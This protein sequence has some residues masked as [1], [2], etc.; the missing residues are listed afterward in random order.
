MPD[1]RSHRG[2]APEDE[3]L[4]DAK[5]W[6]VLRAAIDELCW[7]LDRGYAPHSAAELVGNRH[8]LTARQ[9]MAVSR[10]A[11]TDEA[12]ERRRQHEVESSRLGAQELWID[13]L[14]VLTGVEAA[15][16]GG[17]LLLGCDGC[18]RDLASIH[19]RHH[20]V[21]E[22]LPAL[23]WIGV[24]T[25]AW[26][27]AGCRWWLDRPVA[28]TGRL[29]G[30]MLEMAAANG[31]AWEVE[32]VYNPDKMLI[33]SPAIV[34]SSDSAILDRCGRWVN[35]ARHTIERHVPT[36]RIIDLRRTIGL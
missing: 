33:E 27:V 29:K 34:A 14:N 9:R 24:T 5:S 32:L 7:L 13:G 12:R 17:V 22:T 20:H 15:L 21:E 8:A 1:T 36:A 3:R 6:P 19:A 26:G 23:H 2:P 11:C 31:W 25:N 10:S 35:L 28:N 30:T 18:L 16:A 4:F